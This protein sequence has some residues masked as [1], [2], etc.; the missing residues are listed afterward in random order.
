MRLNNGFNAG[1]RAL[2]RIYARILTPSLIHAAI[3]IKS[4][5]IVFLEEYYPTAWEVVVGVVFE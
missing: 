2:L 4:E 1:Y 3:S 5:I